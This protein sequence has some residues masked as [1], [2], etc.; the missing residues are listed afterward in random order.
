MTE[1]S[2]YIC[3]N[4][5]CKS[6]YVY[7]LGF[8]KNAGKEFI[9]KYRCTVCGNYFEAPPSHKESDAEK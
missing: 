9:Y 7:C 3:R 6:E 1:T 8:T 2:G 5:D 4:Q